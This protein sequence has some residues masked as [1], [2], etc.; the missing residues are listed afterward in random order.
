MPRISFS[1]ITPILFSS[2]DNDRDSVVTESSFSKC[3]RQKGQRRRR[4]SSL[5][6]AEEFCSQDP[7][8]WLDDGRWLTTVTDT[9]LR[10]SDVQLFDPD[11]R[12][13]DAASLIWAGTGKTI[14]E[15]QLQISEGD[16][17]TNEWGYR[18]N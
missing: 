7:S 8:R 11:D 17:Q 13:N 1:R 5:S 12:D 15:S 6:S 9:R 10:L 3:D 18:T 16:R 4:V 14:R 2:P